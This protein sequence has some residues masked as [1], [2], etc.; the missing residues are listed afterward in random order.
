MS[1]RPDTSW[2]TVDAGGTRL[3]AGCRAAEGAGSGEHPLRRPPPSSLSVEDAHFVYR[4]A[5]RGFAAELDGG[6]L[7]AVRAHPE[8]TGVERDA[9][10]VGALVEPVSVA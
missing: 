6:Q 3:K 9:E 5:V 7:E 4:D 2:S 10:A 1:H 8:V